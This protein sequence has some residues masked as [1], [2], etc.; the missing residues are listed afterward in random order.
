MVLF[1]LL[2]LLSLGHLLTRHIIRIYPLT[3]EEVSVSFLWAIV[4]KHQNGQL[5]AISWRKIV[6]FWW[7][8]DDDLCFVLDQR[9]YSYWSLKQQSAGRHVAP[10]THIYRFRANHAVFVLT[11]KCCILGCGEAENTNFIV[12]IVLT[13]PEPQIEPTICRARGE[14]A[15]QI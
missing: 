6:T 12:C 1:E 13:R 3:T 7:D 15:N 5:S 4:V 10:L 11:R 8:D 9:I 2:L 14:H